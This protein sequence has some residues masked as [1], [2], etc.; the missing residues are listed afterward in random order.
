MTARL[1]PPWSTRGTDLGV[2]TDGSIPAYA[3]RK[4]GEK[5]LSTIGYR[6]ATTAAQHRKDPATT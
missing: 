4:V 3:A 5:W 6:L 2:E 1:F